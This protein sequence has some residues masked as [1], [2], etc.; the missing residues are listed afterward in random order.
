MNK[1]I[2]LTRDI[3]FLTIPNTAKKLVERQ[4]EQLEEI[5]TYFEEPTDLAEFLSELSKAIE[6]GNIT[7]DIMLELNM[8]GVISR[9]RVNRQQAQFH[10]SCIA[11]IQAKKQIDADNEVA[12]WPLLCH[13][14]Y[15]IG[16]AETGLT[17]SNEE[18]W[19]IESALP[20]RQL[21]GKVTNEKYEPLRKRMIELLK[22]RAPTGGWKTKKQ[23]VDAIY[24]ELETFISEEPNS[25]IVKDAHN[26]ATSWL[27]KSGNFDINNAYFAN[28]STNQSK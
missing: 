24:S 20:G 19:H 12:A 21:G 14:N 10:M 13:T 15:L 11:Y 28:A 9:T 16:Q 6:V 7:E 2:E 5:S 8:D 3:L 25:D 4:L 18:R 23:A 26:L 27:K 17:E 22:I 1:V